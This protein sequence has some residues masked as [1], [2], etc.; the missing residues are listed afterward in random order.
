MAPNAPLPRIIHDAAERQGCETA[1]TYVCVKGSFILSVAAP[2]SLRAWP[3]LR[4]GSAF[5][6]ALPADKKVLCG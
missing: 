4:R 5:A 6:S 3:T 2:I 1:Q